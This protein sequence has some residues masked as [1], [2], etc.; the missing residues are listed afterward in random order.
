MPAVT[1]PDV[2]ER[3]TYFA[4]AMLS[5][6]VIQAMQEVQPL[7]NVKPAEVT[8]MTGRSIRR[9]SEFIAVLRGGSIDCRQKLLT[10]WSEDGVPTTFY[11]T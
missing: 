6:R 8:T 3:C 11:T 10:R 9:I 1:H 5:G 2:T 7:L 4:A